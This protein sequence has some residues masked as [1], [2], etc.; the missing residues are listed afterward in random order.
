MAVSVFWSKIDYETK[1][2]EYLLGDGWG[3][4][5]EKRYTEETLCQPIVT[6]LP[7]TTSKPKF[8]VS[9]VPLGASS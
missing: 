8:T 5:S 1:R 6:T 4:R 7:S 3:P 2:L 9:S